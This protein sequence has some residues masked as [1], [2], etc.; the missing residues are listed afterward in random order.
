MSG[1]IFI[2]YRR[3]DVPEAAG[4]LFDR[5][6]DVFKHDQLFMDVDSI[7]PGMDFV[8]VLGE[9]VAESD[10]LLAV[11]GKG[12]L[13]ARDAAGERRLDNPED[14]VR[15]EI[16]SAIKQDKLVIPVLVGN[17]EM[18]RSEDLPEELR[19]LARRNAVRLT[20][21]RFR[22]DVQGLIKALQH[23]L[24]G[25]EEVRKAEAER[26]AAEDHQRQETEARRAQEEASKKAL[27]LERKRATE[28]A[29]AA[30]KAQALVSAELA[31]RNLAAEAKPE[32][33]A[34]DEPPVE[35]KSPEPSSAITSATQQKFEPPPAWLLVKPT[36]LA[37]GLIIFGIFCAGAAWLVLSP[38]GL[39]ADKIAATSE[40][41]ATAPSTPAKTPP[42]LATAVP[43]T[44][45]REHV[46][47]PKDTFKECTNCPK[48]VVVPAG[49]FTMGSPSNELG[50]ETNEGPQHVVTVA[51]QF[52]VGRFAVSFDEWDAC[53]AGGGCNG[54]KPPDQGWG[55]GQ[56]PAINVSFDDA[57]AYVSWLSRIT[58]RSYRLLSEAEREYVARAGTTTVFWWGNSISTN[59]AN[60]NGNYTYGN[61]VKGPYRG[62]TTV[63]DTFEANAWG[64]FQ[65]HGNLWEW[66]SDCFRSDYSNAPADG[67]S[68]QTDDCGLRTLR[69]GS[70]DRKPAFLRS[71]SRLGWNHAVRDNSFG[72]RVARTLSP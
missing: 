68:A 38:A 34:A 65:V 28:A 55:R 62:R 23:S 72:F 21:E 7:A 17:A 9:R 64:L 5:L 6:Q 50:R 22:A 26:R 8:R 71:A 44:P 57:A 4:R 63:V 30:K 3:G 13:Q 25:M 37:V 11:I 16:A 42:D 35:E 19:P 52:A 31:T 15:I 24:T 1:K 39:P 49:S 32:T 2:N 18:P 66:V 12:W 14:F 69:G 40:V 54:Y 56:L 53:V 36:F 59:Q 46:L 47:A 61:G 33:P 60:Y 51:R 20:H 70:W 67:S 58:G 27:E 29:E 45:D 41:A 48:M 10:V 43:L